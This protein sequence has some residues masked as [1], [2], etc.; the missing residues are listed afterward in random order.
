MDNPHNGDEPVEISKLDF[1]QLQPD[2]SLKHLEKATEVDNVKTDIKNLLEFPNKT[3]QSSSNDITSSSMIS[4]YITTNSDDVSLRNIIL[5]YRIRMSLRQI[6]TPKV[7]TMG[8]KKRILIIS[9]SLK[10]QKLTH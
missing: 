1:S 9:I 8:N 4:S 2:V 10:S 6:T 5:D 3:N 7:Q